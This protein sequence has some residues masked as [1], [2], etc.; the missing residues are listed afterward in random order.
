MQNEHDAGPSRRGV[1]A[2]GAG[3][4][5]A[6]VA[7]A[8]SAQAGPSKVDI[9]EVRDGRVEFPNWRG[10]ADRPSPPPPAPRPPSKRVGFAIVG[11]GRLTLEELLPAFGEA[12]RAR[13]VAL[14]TGT[15][16]K[17]AAIAAQYGIKPEAIYSYDGFDKI[18]ENPEIEAVYVVLPNGMH[19]EFVVRAAQA[20]KHVLCEKPMATSAAEAREMIAA[21]EAAKVRLMIAYRCQFEPYNREATR[22]VR[23]GE[24]GRPRIIQAANTQTMGP[25]DQWRFDKALAG[26]GA[27]PDIG[28]YCLNGARALLGEEPGEVFAKVWSPQNDDR[29]ATVEETVSFSAWFPSGVMAECAASYGA[30]EHKDLRVHLETGTIDLK[31]AFAYEG[32]QLRVSRRRGK[33]ESEESLRLGQKNQFALEIDHMAQCVRENRRP[34]T[35][36]EEGLQDHILMEAIYRSA[37]QNA[38]VRLDA[39]AGIDTTRG[40]EPDQDG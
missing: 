14:V 24:L 19:K 13:P 34:R 32:Q 12:K 15:P 9:G 6:A 1:I 27:L 10:E 30:H 4:V 33:A 23:S 16:E 38:P 17:A 40:P 18:A 5:G 11:L 20:G 26:G 25:K 29:Y 28:L 35:P 2:A 36:G 22:L 31:R 3:I 8:G 21:C 39:V 7:G 37:E